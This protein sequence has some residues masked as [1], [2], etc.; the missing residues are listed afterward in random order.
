MLFSGSRGGGRG[1]G[2]V[3]PGKGT[4]GS[5]H[6]RTMFLKKKKVQPVATPST[7]PAKGQ[8]S[9]GSHSSSPS[10]PAASPRASPPGSPGSRSPTS[11]RGSVHVDQGDQESEFKVA[12][13]LFER[14]IDGVTHLAF[15]GNSTVYVVDKARVVSEGKITVSS[16]VK[17]APFRVVPS[18]DPWTSVRVFRDLVH[19]SIDSFSFLQSQ[20]F[21]SIPEVLC[22]ISTS[23]DG[24]VSQRAPSRNFQFMPASIR[25][26]NI[27]IPDAAVPEALVREGVIWAKV[28][29]MPKSVAR[30]NGSMVKYPSVSKGCF[31]LCDQNGVVLPRS[32]PTRAFSPGTI[33]ALKGGLGANLIVG[34]S[35]VSFSDSGCFVVSD[36]ALEDFGFD[37]STSFE[38]LLRA[39]SVQAEASDQQKG[40]FSNHFGRLVNKSGLNPGSQPTV[41]FIPNFS[42][43]L[44]TRAAETLAVRAVRAGCRALVLVPSSITSTDANYSDVNS[45]RANE[46]HTSTLYKINQP[47]QLGVLDRGYYDFDDPNCATSLMAYDILASD[48]TRFDNSLQ[49]PVVEVDLHGVSPLDTSYLSNPKSKFVLHISIT[50]SALKGTGLKGKLLGSFTFDNDATGRSH[51]LASLK[52]FL[53]SEKAREDVVALLKRFDGATSMKPEDLNPSVSKSAKVVSVKLLQD[54][55][56]VSLIVT[57][58][59]GLGC[60]S[61]GMF[62]TSNDTLRVRL[63]TGMSSDVFAT[64]C[65]LVNRKLG[66]AF[67]RLLQG[68]RGV[69][70]LEDAFLVDLASDLGPPTPR[71]FVVQGHT[72]DLDVETISVFVGETGGLQPRRIVGYK[73][74]SFLVVDWPF[75]AP[76]N[77]VYGGR[78]FRFVP[79]VAKEGDV[80][81]PVVAESEMDF[82]AVLGDF[83]S[84]NQI[85]H[86]LPDSYLEALMALLQGEQVEQK[87]S[88]SMEVDPSV[89]NL[90]EKELQKSP[91]LPEGSLT[92]QVHSPSE[93]LEDAQEAV[94]PSFK[95]VQAGGEPPT[96]V[97][98]STPTKEPPLQL[99]SGHEP[100]VQPIDNPS[101][102]ELNKVDPVT[103]VTSDQLSSLVTP[104]APAADPSLAMPGPTEEVN[105]RVEEPIAPSKKPS[106][107]SL[108][109]KGK[110]EQLTSKAPSTVNQSKSLANGVATEFDLFPEETSPAPPGQP[111]VLGLAGA[112]PGK[113]QRSPSD[114]LAQ[115][116]AKSK[117]V[118]AKEPPLSPP[119]GDLTELEE[120]WAAWTKDGLTSIC[121]TRGITLLVTNKLAIIKVLVS[122]R[123]PYKAPPREFQAAV[124]RPAAVGSVSLRRS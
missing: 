32:P 26:F 1:G 85:K 120:K 116:Q 57:F 82:G 37:G 80:P 33:A 99:D 18:K 124:I 29:F 53:P 117:P 64:K 16:L 115:A 42:G 47:V 76:A 92:P 25:A 20:E 40:Y 119:M 2:R 46:V 69:L 97:S 93:A 72:A 90:R 22:R 6:E 118:E 58:L 96:K 9:P 123:V 84:G 31:Q 94:P 34:G 21:S 78:P 91:G 56:P 103:P 51:R 63:P 77:G 48:S 81:F 10:S 43:A 54:D 98:S 75:S 102:S 105:K 12:Y 8:G 86:P 17:G 73:Q 3:V 67:F 41:L 23:V 122:Q 38:E 60:S 13:F 114:L 110:G 39:V 83:P 61:D 107:A 89:E 66:K 79:Y 109:D 88:E 35:P 121:K 87:A 27:Q 111:L 49:Y 45:P 7:Q 113:R 19:E 11:E 5:P 74:G 24:L 95:L 62:F 59:A 108:L 50:P 65:R 101:V 44:S 104:A 112:T 52:A 15:L 106:D 36:W 68:E 70:N 55:L 4:T 100:G 28:K 71:S 14:E 30:R